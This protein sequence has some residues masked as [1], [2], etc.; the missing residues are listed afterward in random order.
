MWFTSTQNDV[1]SKGTRHLNIGQN[2][3]PLRATQRD[4][5]LERRDIKC[6]PW[7]SHDIASF[8]ASL[9]RGKLRTEGRVLFFSRERYDRLENPR[10]PP[11]SGSSVSPWKTRTICTGTLASI[12]AKSG[13][14]L[15]LA[16]PFFFLAKSFATRTHLRICIHLFWWSRPTSYKAL[17]KTRRNSHSN[18]A[19]GITNT[20]F[21]I[22]IEKLRDNSPGKMSSEANPFGYSSKIR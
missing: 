13:S 14:H 9:T 11:N 1:S 8:N 17:V 18:K 2:E 15:V 3:Y 19:I 10:R 6:E 4:I 12:L 5:K 22:V 7:D 20:V 21:I 16:H